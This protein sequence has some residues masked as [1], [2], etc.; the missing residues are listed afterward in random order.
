MKKLVMILAMAALMLT[1]AAGVTGCGCGS[2]VSGTIEDGSASGGTPTTRHTTER[3]TAGTSADH[4]TLPEDNTA[5]GIV[6][7]AIDDTVDGIGNAVDDT[8]DGIDNAMGGKSSGNSANNGR[9][10]D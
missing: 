7:N 2:T 10:R 4:G 9:V 6:G 1:T 5:D 3:T 8:I